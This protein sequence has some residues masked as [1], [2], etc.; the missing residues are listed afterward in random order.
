[1]TDEMGCH[2]KDCDLPVAF[3][4]AA[5]ARPCCPNHGRQVALERREDPAGWLADHGVLERV[6]SHTEFYLLCL[7]CSTR[8]FGGIPRHSAASGGLTPVP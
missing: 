4:C 3:V 5:C 7:R 6:P 1:M 2:A 8:P